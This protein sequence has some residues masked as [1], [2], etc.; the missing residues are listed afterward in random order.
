MEQALYEDPWYG[1]QHKANYPHWNNLIYTEDSELKMKQLAW[2]WEMR[3]YFGL[4]FNQVQEFQ[5]NWNKYFN[6][7]KEY[8]MQQSPAKG[9]N[10]T[11]T[12]IAYW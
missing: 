7:Y 3:T 2:I 1:L 5:A 6:L 10:A 12:G 8:W 4:S 9:Y 11:Q